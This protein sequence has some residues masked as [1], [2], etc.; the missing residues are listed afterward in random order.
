VS[1]KR[2]LLSTP[3]KLF[4]ISVYGNS[5]CHQLNKSQDLVRPEGRDKLIKFIHLIGS[6]MR[7]LPDKN[8]AHKLPLLR[9][10]EALRWFRG[11]KT[12]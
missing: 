2:R 1:L 6:R 12:T 5:F 11:Q 4:F 8:R 9:N 3:K 7:D 10:A